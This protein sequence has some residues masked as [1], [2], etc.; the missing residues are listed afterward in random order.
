MLETRA[1]EIDFEPRYGNFKHASAAN[2]G[3]KDRGRKRKERG[4]TGMLR[5]TLQRSLMTDSLQIFRQGVIKGAESNE[6]QDESARSIVF[7]Q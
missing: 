6:L 7:I 2:F 5:S 4:R 1:S 3:K